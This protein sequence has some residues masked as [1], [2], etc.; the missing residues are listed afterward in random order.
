MEITQKWRNMADLYR[1][2]CP[3]EF[4]GDFSEAAALEMF[5]YESAGIGKPSP[6]NGYAQGKSG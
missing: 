5:N 6:K 2:F 1:K 3:A 4:E